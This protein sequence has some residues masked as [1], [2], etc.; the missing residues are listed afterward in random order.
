MVLDIEVVYQGE[1]NS[2]S[3]G[4]GATNFPSNYSWG[5]GQ[6]V[7]SYGVI[8]LV[9]GS[10]PARA[11]SAAHDKGFEI[12]PDRPLPHFHTGTKLHLF[13]NGVDRKLEI[14]ATP[15]QASTSEQSGHVVINVPDVAE[16]KTMVAGITAGTNSK[17]KILKG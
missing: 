3:F 16:L 2:I 10:E 5:F 8:Y 14:T 11:G 4:V 9:G 7:L 6:Q 17:L 13:Y 15:R 12:Q 1:R